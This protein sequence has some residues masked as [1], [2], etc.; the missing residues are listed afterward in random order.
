VVIFLPKK[1]DIKK[2]AKAVEV[3]A[4]YDGN[5]KTFQRLMEELLK[6]MLQK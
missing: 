2:T 3:S 5:G 4:I 6:T 1:R